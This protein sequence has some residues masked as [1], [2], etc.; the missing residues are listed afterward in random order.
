MAG[1]RAIIA[2]S[3]MKMELEAVADGQSVDLYYLDQGLHRTPQVM[4]L[5]IQE[6]IDELAPLNHERICLGYGLCSNGILGV[7]GRTSPLTT[8]RCHD[9]IALFLG[10]NRRYR[11]MFRKNPGTYYLTAGWIVASDDPLTAVEGRYAQR[12]GLKKAK[13]AMDLELANY[14]HFCFIDNGLGDRAAVKART[15]ENCRAFQKEYLE[16]QGDLTYFRSLVAPGIPENAGDFITL[17]PGSALDEAMF[18]QVGE[19]GVF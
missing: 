3:I 13:R 11:V 18:Y 1:R 17:P 16:V 10:S 8:P 15:L 4:P 14:T 19:P 9:C 6:K 12:M 7:S 5:R 2:C